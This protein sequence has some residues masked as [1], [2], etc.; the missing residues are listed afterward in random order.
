MTT[1][2]EREEG[3]GKTEVQDLE[4]HTTMYKT[5]KKH[6]YIVQHRELQPLIAIICKE[7]QS[8]KVPND[9]ATIHLEQI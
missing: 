8:I 2:G 6:E 7:V 1:N 4:I 3:R 5:D 9:Y